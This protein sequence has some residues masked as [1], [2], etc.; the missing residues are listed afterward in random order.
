MSV[1]NFV[2]FLQ[3][4]KKGGVIMKNILIGYMVGAYF[5]EFEP[6]REN[7]FKEPEK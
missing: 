5:V 1:T 6:Y 3:Y 7:E 2:T 4:K